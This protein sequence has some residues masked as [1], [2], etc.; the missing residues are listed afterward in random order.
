MARKIGTTGKFSWQKLASSGDTQ[1]D[2]R[3]WALARDAIHEYCM[4]NRVAMALEM[5]AGE[6][7]TS[8]RR[9]EFKPQV[10]L[11]QAM[12]HLGVEG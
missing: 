7:L 11:R 6:I 2:T 1:S 3:D 8:L 4:I 9:A 5:E 12:R 10:A